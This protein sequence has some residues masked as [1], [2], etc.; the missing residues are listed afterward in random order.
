MKLL[1]IQGLLLGVLAAATSD[2]AAQ[3]YRCQADGKVVYQQAPCTGGTKL[4]VEPAVDPLSRA[5]RI[6]SAVARG[7]V[8]V[9]MTQAQVLQSWGPPDKK[10]RSIRATG[11]SE[12]WIYNR[13]DI[14][15]DQYLY[16]EDGLLT[17]VQTPE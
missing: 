11:T 9:G 15:R 12:Q 3:A 13:G 1:L 7:R 8:M 2:L 17:S 6:A 16:L 10:N 4:N 14:G 5:G